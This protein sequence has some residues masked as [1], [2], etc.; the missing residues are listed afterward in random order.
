MLKPTIH[1]NGTSAKQLIARY[2]K[3]FHSLSDAIESLREC[4]PNGR[5]YYPQSAHAINDACAEHLDRV[6][7]L[8]NVQNELM[9]IMLCIRKQTKGDAK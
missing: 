2:K 4:T 3:A 6:V 8:E 7:A 5:D 1:T 9:D